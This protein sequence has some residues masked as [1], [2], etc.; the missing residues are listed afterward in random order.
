MWSAFDFKD[1]QA[2]VAKRRLANFDS[3]NRYKQSTRVALAS[4]ATALPVMHLGKKKLKTM[5]TEKALNLKKDTMGFLQ[6]VGLERAFKVYLMKN[7]SAIQF[8]SKPLTVL[9]R[10]G[11]YFF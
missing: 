6:I 1:T 10:R 11:L 7:I 8:S 3:Q 2:V 5:F 9:G 4:N